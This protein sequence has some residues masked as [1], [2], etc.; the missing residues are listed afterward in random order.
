[1]GKFYNHLIKVRH[2]K[3]CLA[4]CFNLLGVTLLAQIKLQ[5]ADLQEIFQSYDNIRDFTI[6]ENGKEAYFTILSPKEEISIIVKIRKENNKWISPEITEFSGKFK[7]LEPFLSKDGLR[8]YFAS[9]RSS[10]KRDSLVKDFDIWYVERENFNEKWSNPINIGAPVNSVD[11][12]FYPSLAANGNLYFTSPREGSKG[13]DD[14]FLSKWNGEN[15]ETPVSLPAAI[16]SDGYEFN[17]Y[18]AP[19]ES[20]LIFTGYDRIDG[21]GSGDLYIS[22]KISANEW[23]PALNLGKPYNSNQMDYCPFIDFNSKSIYLT[24]RRS[25]IRTDL[26]Y[27]TVDEFLNEIKRYENGF[28]RIYQFSIELD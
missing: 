2:L 15:Y 4:L 21:L 26:E 13:K 9:N 10:N 22:R 12:E 14:I 23:S 6:S 7:D 5:N 20:F 17:A 19:D 18:I 24:S 16:N 11:D 28:S 8:L 25:E 27:K 1:M 3:L